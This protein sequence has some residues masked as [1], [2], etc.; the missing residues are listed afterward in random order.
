MSRRR[1][2]VVAALLAAIGTA[3]VIPSVAS[4]S[5][6][7]RSFVNPI[8]TLINSS[9]I[10]NN[11]ILSQDI[12]NNSLLTTD[13]RDFTILS[14]DLSNYIITNNKMAPGSIKLGNLDAEVMA[15]V[16]KMIDD[17]VA[18]KIAALTIPAGPRA[19]GRVKADGTVDATVSKNISAR[20]VGNKYCV[21][22][23]G[24]TDPTKIAPVVTASNDSVAAYAVVSSM[25][26]CSANEFGVGVYFSG[27]D[28]EADF[29]VYV[30]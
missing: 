23:T 1:S 3:V 24:V 10:I 14:N 22:V 15:S 4:G 20:M 26:Q 21:S 5:S 12:R 2:L 17:T 28:I 11:S 9:M 27:S 8:D 25:N 29:N 19:Y 7:S 13:I 16:Q 30:P 6:A 18:T